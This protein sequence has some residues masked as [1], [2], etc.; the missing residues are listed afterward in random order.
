L[1]NTG[2]GSVMKGRGESNC[3]FSFLRKGD[4]GRGWIRKKDEYELGGALS[5]GGARE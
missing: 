4:I 1:I 2:R 5:G 3:C